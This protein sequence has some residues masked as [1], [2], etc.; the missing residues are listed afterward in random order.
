MPVGNDQDVLGLFCQ[1][2]QHL[3]AAHQSNAGRSAKRSRE[4]HCGFGEG[5]S[6]AGTPMEQI[7]PFS[8]SVTAR[9]NS[10]V[11]GILF[12]DVH[13]QKVNGPL[14]NNWGSRTGPN[15]IFN[16]LKIT[17]DLENF[18]SVDGIEC[19]IQLSGLADD[20]PPGY[21]FLSPLV[22]LETDASA[23]LR[24]LDRPVYWSLDP[25]G[26]G[27]LRDEEAHDLGFPAIYVEMDVLGKS[28]DAS[29]YDGIHQFQECKGFDPYSQEV[30][31]ELGYLHFQVSG[32]QHTTLAHLRQPDNHDCCSDSDEISYTEE[33]SESGDEQYDSASERGD[34]ITIQNAQIN[35]RS[36]TKIED[37][38]LEDIAAA[39][40]G[41]SAVPEI[42]VRSGS[43]CCGGEEVELPATSSFNIVIT[44]QF[45][46]ILT[47]TALSLYD[48]F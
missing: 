2:V 44:A 34:A 18:V 21:L 14:A 6:T 45:F 3:L 36:C 40:A 42:S 5:R 11:S 22:E 26:L 13:L 10:W 30:T 9:V 12:W 7:T 31:V 16:R 19:Y 4:S 15:T 23:T 41:H 27:R 38:T 29:V 46:L 1:S 48:S 32:D 25:C 37:H 20:L 35:L 8:H 17:W 33:L 24:T 39:N 43:Q 47:A 28:W